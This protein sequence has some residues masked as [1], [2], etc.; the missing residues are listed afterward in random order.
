MAKGRQGFVIEGLKFAVY[1]AIPLAASAYFNDPAHL[2]EAADYWQL[3]R[4]PAN[5]TTDVK[6]AVEAVV[7]QQRQRAAYRR[8][9]QLLDRRPDYP[10]EPDVPERKGWLRWIGFGASPPPPSSSSFPS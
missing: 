5:P 9:L 3:V 2:K 6:V 10:T 7:E 4:Y 1:L 8:Q